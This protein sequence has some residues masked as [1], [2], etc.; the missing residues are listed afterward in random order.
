ML[1]GIS[2][3]GDSTTDGGAT[4]YGDD[5]TTDGGATTDDGETTDGGA[6]VGATLCVQL[7][8]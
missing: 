6:V 4:T 7:F 8:A 3:G 2:D 1:F 5:S